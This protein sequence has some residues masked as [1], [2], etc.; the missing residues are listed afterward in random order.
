[1]CSL[2]EEVPV[3]WKHPFAEH[4]ASDPGDQASDR[5]D[6]ASDENHQAS[7]KVTAENGQKLKFK[8]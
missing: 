2:P 8:I 5:A 6:Q 3:C 7:D 4:Q 1:M